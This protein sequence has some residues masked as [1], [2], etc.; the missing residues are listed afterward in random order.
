VAALL[1]GEVDIIQDVPVQ[2]LDACRKCRRT[3]SRQRAAE[4]HHFLRHQQGDDDLETDNVEG[5]NPFADVRVRKAMNMAINREAIKQVV[6]RG[7]SAPT[8]V[9][10]PPFVNGWTRGAGRLSETTSKLPR[11]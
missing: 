1:S 11:P 6:M 2:D 10:M 8:G 5:K 4:P 7:Q 9:I 3:E